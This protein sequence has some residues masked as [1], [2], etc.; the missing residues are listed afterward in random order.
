[1]AILLCSVEVETAWPMLKC[2]CALFGADVQL[3]A[4][5]SGCESCRKMEM[6]K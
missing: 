6:S 5:N 1:M 2:A 3:I 4:V